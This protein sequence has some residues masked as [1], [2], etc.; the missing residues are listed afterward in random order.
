MTV[1]SVDDSSLQGGL[2]VQ[3]CWFGLSDGA[4]VHLSDELAVLTTL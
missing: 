1:V 2:T 3:V 4:V